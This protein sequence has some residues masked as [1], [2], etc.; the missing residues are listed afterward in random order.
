MVKKRRYTLSEME[1]INKT[2]G[3]PFFSKGA[4]AGLDGMKYT[5]YYN[6]KKGQNY[7]YSEWG[8]YHTCWYTFNPDNGELNYISE[9]RIPKQVM[10][11]VN[12]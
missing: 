4:M 11:E 8:Q 6:E 7:L 3:R 1:T 10:G 5:P 12:K 2:N 9:S